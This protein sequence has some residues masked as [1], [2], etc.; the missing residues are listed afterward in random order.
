MFLL[1]KSENFILSKGKNFN[2]GV[3]NSNQNDLSWLFLFSDFF[4]IFLISISWFRIFGVRRN[5]CWLFTGWFD[6]F[7]APIV[8]AV[9]SSQN[10]DAMN[11]RRDGK[12]PSL[13]AERVSEY[14]Q[15]RIKLKHSFVFI[16]FFAFCLIFP[17]FCLIVCLPNAAPPYAR[18]VY[19]VL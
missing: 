4:Q 19:S 10:F 5:K 6:F 2:F 8:G 9:N 1:E 3:I 11:V 17:S 15:W 18:T 14:F 7:F 13:Q 12:S 16:S